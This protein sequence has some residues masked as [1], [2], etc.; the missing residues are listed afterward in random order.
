MPTYFSRAFEMKHSR[1]FEIAYVGLKFGE[2]HYVYDINDR[3]LDD[4]GYEGE[5]LRQ[6]NCKVNLTFEKLTNLFQLKFDLDGLVTV[7]CDRCGDDME[8]QIWDEHHL[9]IKISFDENQQEIIEE[10]DVIFLPKHETVIDISKW[11]YEFLLL[12]IPMQH[13]HDDNELETTACNKEVLKKLNQYRM[14]IETRAVEERKNIWK[15][16]DKLKDNN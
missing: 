5:E 2:H 6:L 9:I 4:M 1:L 13:I 3:F 16:L 7:A 12:S 15:G 10:D 14:E 11:I 8:L